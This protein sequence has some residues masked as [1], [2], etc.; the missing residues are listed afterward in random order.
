MQT[1]DVLEVLLGKYFYEVVFEA[2]SGDDSNCVNSAPVTTEK[3]PNGVWDSVDGGK[4]LVFTPKNVK[5]S[6]KVTFDYHF[7]FQFLKRFFSFYRS[8]AMI[9]MVRS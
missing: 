6:N 8:L 5:A 4:M 3:G 9:S 7:H 2:E 1:G